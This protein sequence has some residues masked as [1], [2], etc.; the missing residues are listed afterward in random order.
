MV[1]VGFQGEDIF[2]VC[3]VQMDDAPPFDTLS[4][5][6]VQVAAVIERSF[7][8]EVYGNAQI[9]GNEIVCSF[10][11]DSFDVGRYTAQITA[12]KLGVTRLV[13]EFTLDVRRSI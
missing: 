2:V 11:K 6:T 4:G 9:I 12:T 1:I 7:R 8:P 10:L 5:A 13:S 3:E